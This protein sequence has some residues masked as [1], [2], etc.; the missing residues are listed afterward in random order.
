[1]SDPTHVERRLRALEDEIGVVR[2]RYV[3]LMLAIVGLAV[4]TVCGVGYLYGEHATREPSS[5]RSGENML[6]TSY[7]LRFDYEGRKVL[8]DAHG[9]LEFRDGKVFDLIAI[10]QHCLARAET[11]GGTLGSIPLSCLSRDEPV[12][13]HPPR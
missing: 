6:L 2:R 5:A 8:V 3:R 4:A 1:M 13:K 7:S 12:N 9:V 10:E 11:E